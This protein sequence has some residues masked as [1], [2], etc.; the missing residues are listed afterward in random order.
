MF[1][2]PL[3]LMA[4]LALPTFQAPLSAQAP[5]FTVLYSFT[6]GPDG[7]N[8]TTAT[9]VRDAH[10]NL[11]GTTQFGADV[12]CNVSLHPGCG[13]VFELHTSGKL[14]ALHTFQGGSLGLASSGLVM[15][16]KGNLYGTAG[17]GLGQGF[18]FEVAKNG[19]YTELYDFTGGSDGNLP[20]GNLFRDAAGNL[21]GT[22]LLGGG[23]SDPFCPNNQG[24]GTVFEFG[25][26][27]NY[28]VLYSFRNNSDGAEPQGVIRDS[29]GNLFGVTLQ[30]GKGCVPVS[31]CG[32]IFKLDA[33]GKKTV[34][35]YFSGGK[36]GSTPV[37]RLVM[38]SAGSLYGVTSAG[39]DL[40]CPYNGG[41]G[42]GVVFKLNSKNVLTVLHAFHGGSDGNVPVSV[43]PDTAGNL[44]GTTQSGPHANT[45]GTV[46]KLDARGKLT[47]LHN[48]A[49]GSE[50]CGPVG[51]LVRDA[52]GH[53]YGAAV[54]GG[55][56]G[57]PNICLNG[58]GTLFEIKP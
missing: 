12:N 51:E 4:F 45:C 49:G 19:T 22:T 56:F 15:D 48:L 36:D 43:I 9:M 55:Y 20:A 3:M 39:G 37:G 42:C 54:L 24:C 26:A 47:N 57:N 1:A 6:G 21:Y 41:A 40:A 14:T 28:K 23:S 34:L 50:G 31:G 27:G 58:C 35:H 13:T 32:T 10:G 7:A 8:P 53:L 5:T 38:D 29:A 52:G 46:F 16:G 11:Y 2:L 25:P 17:G 44:Y 30:G 18:V 33:T